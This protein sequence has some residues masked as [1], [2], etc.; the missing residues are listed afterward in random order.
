MAPVVARG[1]AEPASARAADN[2]A[3]WAEL[4]S[5]SAAPM[6]EN[7]IPARYPTLD[8]PSQ[9]TVGQP[10]QVSFA[11]TTLDLGTAAVT[12]R[13]AVRA[14]GVVPSAPLPWYTYARHSFDSPLS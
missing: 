4:G 10:F 3:F 9:V 12:I 8:G 7:Q 5:G 1:D 13:G 11:L 14:S 2:Q 6:A